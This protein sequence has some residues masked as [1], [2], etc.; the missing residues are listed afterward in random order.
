MAANTNFLSALG[1]AVL[2]SL[3][4]MAVLW[5]I[6][7]LLFSGIKKTTAAFRSTIASLFLIVGFV[8]FVVTFFFHFNML[9]H[10]GYSPIF[11]GSEMGN[12]LGNFIPAISIVYLFLLL[13]T[14][15]RFIKNYRYVQVIRKYGLSKA[16]IDWRT[17]VK[18]MSAQLSIKREVKVWISDFVS[19]PVTIGWIKPIILLPV[20]ALNHLSIQQVE[21]LLLHELAHI[22]R[23]DYLL[24]LIINF[25]RTILFFNPF[26]TALIKITE[27]QREKSCDELVLQ[28]QYPAYDYVAALLE[29]QKQNAT[30]QVF[31]LPATGRFDLLSRA[32]I[33]MGIA[34]ERKFTKRH[35]M[36]L[37]LA[38]LIIFASFYFEHKNI[39]GDKTAG[40]SLGYKRSNTPVPAVFV[41]NKSV[42]L[43]TDKRME[44]S[45][46]THPA[47]V[48]NAIA[49]LQAP[50]SLITNSDPDPYLFV[51]YQQDEAIPE[52]KEYQKTQVEQAIASSKKVVEDLQWKAIEKNLAEVF[53]QIEKQ[54]LKKRYDKELG[55]IDWK[56]W[57]K[58]LS[59]AYSKIDWDNVNAQLNNAVNMVRIDSIQQVY[60]VALAKLDKAHKVLADNS[61]SYLPDTDVSAELVEQKR[62]EAIEVLKKITETKKKKIVHL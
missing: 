19:S 20:A 45:V 18:R 23:S 26:V 30:Q 43:A 47:G 36:S 28:F 15:S 60:N 56:I 62:K 7:Q 12:S 24:N 61:L 6:S 41:N 55:K 49:F 51:N 34:K 32:E 3:W 48:K 52:L 2:H 9:Q 42:E 44:L 31:A 17:F 14:A 25:I 37:G 40:I 27:T 13:L 50:P 21:A 35:L 54:E 16:N 22:K 5:I 59:A 1:W 57:E 8:S 29:M 39:M 10:G 53:T 38:F 33:I 4:Q 46:A 11:A 58:K